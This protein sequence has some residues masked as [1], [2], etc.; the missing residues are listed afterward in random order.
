MYVKF[1]FHSYQNS[2]QN[3]LHKIR[4]VGAI[5]NSTCITDHVYNFIKH[6]INSLKS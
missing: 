3:I 2:C 1:Y 4:E 6:C 5:V